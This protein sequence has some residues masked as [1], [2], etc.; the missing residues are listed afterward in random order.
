MRIKKTMD[1]KN[2]NNIKNIKIGPSDG[3]IIFRSEK[4]ELHIPEE[5]DQDSMNIKFLIYYIA[6]ALEREDWVNEFGETMFLQFVEQEKK[7][8]KKPHLK[9]VK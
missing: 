7:K 9:L 3:A 8:N 5:S 2:Q 4:E 6:H 1:E